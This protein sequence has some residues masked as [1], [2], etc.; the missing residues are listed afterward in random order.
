MTKI[1][2][3]EGRVVKVGEKEVRIYI[4]SKY[5]E[6]VGEYAGWRVRGLL[7]IEEEEKKKKE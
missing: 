5:K 3:F 7:L 1:V 4:Y 6:R 2:Y